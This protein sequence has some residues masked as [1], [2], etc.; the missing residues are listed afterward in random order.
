MAVTQLQSHSPEPC[1]RTGPD[2]IS[3]SISSPSVLVY[4][5][6]TWAETVKKFKDISVRGI[7]AQLKTH[8]TQNVFLVNYKSCIKQT[9]ISILVA[10]SL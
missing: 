5:G 2:T 9:H 10:T 4:L 7:F 3:K 6:V 8:L 1:E